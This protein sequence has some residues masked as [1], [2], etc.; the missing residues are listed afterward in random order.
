MATSSARRGHR[1]ARR[2]VGRG[3]RPHCSRIRSHPGHGRP[4]SSQ[5]C[6]VAKRRPHDEQ[7]QHRC[8]AHPVHV[9]PIDLASSRRAARLPSSYRPAHRCAR[10]VAR[11]R[12]PAVSRSS[13]V[14][15][16]AS[17]LPPSTIASALRFPSIPSFA[18]LPALFSSCATR[19]TNF[20]S[21]RPASPPLADQ[22][23]R[24]LRSGS[25]STTIWPIRNPAILS[26]ANP[27]D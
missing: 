9:N 2:V 21:T 8:V 23:A 13:N 11:V 27:H 4:T 20:T 18:T 16:P 17:P 7:V 25:P 3:D 6:D 5:P 1:G 14:S 12:T 15:L 22:P 26:C 19:P 10:G 24:E